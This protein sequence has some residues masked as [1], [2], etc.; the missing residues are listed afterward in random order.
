MLVAA[1]MV[2]PGQ[3]GC[4]LEQARVVILSEFILNSFQEKVAAQVSVLVASMPYCLYCIYY[5]PDCIT[6]MKLLLRRTLLRSV[7]LFTNNSA[8]RTIAEYV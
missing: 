4:H 6:T 7:I 2:L 1:P 3:R 5:E 8:S